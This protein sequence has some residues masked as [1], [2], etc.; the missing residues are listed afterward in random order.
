MMAMAMATWFVGSLKRW[1]AAHTGE[2]PVSSTLQQSFSILVQKTFVHLPRC[3]S[4]GS[5]C[6]WGLA[7]GIG[8]EARLWLMEHNAAIIWLTPNGRTGLCSM[9]TAM[10]SCPRFQPSPVQWHDID[11]MQ[12]CAIDVHVHRLIC[13]R[14]SSKHRTRRQSVSIV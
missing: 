2:H 14:F 10:I 1:A 3:W 4:S 12:C 7:L 13:K 9:A 11:M 6:M 5:P 8:G